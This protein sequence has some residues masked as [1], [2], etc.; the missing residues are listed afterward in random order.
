M[1][2]TIY[3]FSLVTVFVIGSA[4]IYDYFTISKSEAMQI[5][6]KYIAS[7]SF[8]WKIN[9]IKSENQ[10]WVVHLTP[11]PGEFQKE[12]TWLYIDKHNGEIAKVIESE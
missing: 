2:K 11:A 4:L 10:V 6:D 9:E 8:K 12:A 5:S 7:K 1:K 3:I